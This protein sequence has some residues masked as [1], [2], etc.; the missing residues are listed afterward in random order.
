[1]KRKKKK[2][3][4]TTHEFTPEELEKIQYALSQ[5]VP[6]ELIETRPG[7]GGK[8]LSYIDGSVVITLANEVFGFNGW[9]STARDVI[10]QHQTINPNGSITAIATAIVRITLKNGTFHEVR[11]KGFF[12]LFGMI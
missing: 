12:F 9:S 1:M 6:K 3:M 11:R 5:Q 4:A 2:K 8:K 10:I 7:P